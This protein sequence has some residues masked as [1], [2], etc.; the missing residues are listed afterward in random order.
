MST[1]PVSRRPVLSEYI[2][3]FS[4]LNLVAH[5]QERQAREEFAADDRRWLE[6]EIERLRTMLG[7]C[8]A[9]VE[10]GAEETGDSEELAFAER[11]RREVNL[12]ALEQSPDFPKR[13]TRHHLGTTIEEREGK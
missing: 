12:S 4:K 6:R 8:L 2:E 9:F 7:Q 10:E 3:K 5:E 1:D 11:L 13:D